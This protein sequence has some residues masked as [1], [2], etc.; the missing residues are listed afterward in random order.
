MF[1]IIGLG[2]PTNKYKNNRHNIGFK[3]VDNFI[4]KHQAKLV[5]SSKFKGELFQT[6]RA[7]ILK[8][9]TF[10]N[11]SGISVQLVKNFYKIDIN[12]IIVV[13]DELDL[14]FLSIKYKF[15]GGNSGHN[16]LK[17]I[18]ECITNN[19]FRIRIGIGKPDNKFEIANYVLNDFTKEESLELENIINS[20]SNSI[21]DFFSKT[22]SEIQ[23]IHTIK[24]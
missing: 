12:K 7:F 13:H 21:S 20:T 6:N 4:S 3:V 14:N 1:L 17:S 16:G 23:S 19:Y 15:S 8:P 24:K 2:N 22:L 9:N 18:D 10:M 5:S 11:S